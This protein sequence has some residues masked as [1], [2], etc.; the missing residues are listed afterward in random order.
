MDHGIKWLDDIQTFYRE[1][2]LIEKEYSQKLS[3]L[4]SKY[5]EK[6]AKLSSVLSVGE[7][8]EV[9]P[10]S[11]ESA[12]LV[13]WTEILT[14]TE[15]IAKEKARLASEMTLQIADQTHGLSLK[16]EGVRKALQ[17][18]HEKLVE[19]RDSYYGVLK[20]SK[21]G[22]YDACQAVESQRMKGQKGS[23]LG[24][25]IGHSKEKMERRLETK[26]ADMNDAKNTYLIKINVANRVKDK[27][28][29][30]DMPELLDRYQ[31]LNELRVGLLNALW[32][33]A[34]SVEVACN[35]RCS[36][37][38]EATQAVIA[39]N[40]PA[41]DSVMFTKHNIAP[42]GWEEP[43][44]F[45]YEPC[46]IWHDDENM[47]LD[48]TSL[49][50]LHT[51]LNDSQRLAHQYE[52]AIASKETSFRELEQRKKN[53]LDEKK[54]ETESAGPS[55]QSTA[56]GPHFE[57]LSHS[58]TAL[59]NLTVEDTKRTI[60][61]V[62]T[63]TINFNIGDKDIHSYQPVAI[64]KRHNFLFGKKKI[65]REIP[66]PKAP[67]QP[68]Q[69]GG[70]AGAGKLVLDT[71]AYREGD[72]VPWGAR[73]LIGL[74]LYRYEPQGADEVFISEGE[75]VV[76]VEQDD[77]SGW[78]NVR[79]SDGSEGLVPASYVDLNPPKT[80]KTASSEHSGGGVGGGLRSAFS[81]KKKGP[82]VAPK[83]GA[84]KV[85]YVTALYDYSAQDD[86]EL[87]ISAG[88][89]IVVIEEDRDGWTEGEL[90]G[91]RGA[92]PSSYVQ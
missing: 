35:E 40:K 70:L 71:L 20:K 43:V 77:G 55:S 44:D 42:N 61:E 75:E 34:G 68:G 54:K 58:I 5:F 41:L 76:V 22:Y 24:G 6:K 60:A 81:I 45:V 13:T 87:S 72:P 32:K 84:K 28:Y 50:F 64:K 66:Q 15:Q 18:F 82:P 7:H 19:D 21:T 62:E 73:D 69:G 63:E 88:D 85:S 47:V 2:A 31:E 12:S 48:D 52:D 10:G 4:S 67:K 89:Q 78:I 51:V 92:F 49:R 39:Q 46:P 53:K 90:N 9:T 11:L 83:Q 79:K 25:L 56:S 38:L 57:L 59:R 37:H 80:P 14:Q 3:Q 8:P 30:Q 36:E 29:H 23:S 1:R 17:S 91:S 65:D 33:H 86:S 74:V 27:Y 16:S 26:Q